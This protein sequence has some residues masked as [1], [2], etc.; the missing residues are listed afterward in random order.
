MNY[1]IQDRCELDLSEH[2]QIVADPVAAAY[3]LN[4]LDPAHPGR[5]RANPCCRFVGTL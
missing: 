5:S 2:F 3:V 4:A 1:V